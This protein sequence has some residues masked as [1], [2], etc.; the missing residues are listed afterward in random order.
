MKT[1]FLTGDINWKTYGGKFITK[2]L[3]NGDFDYYIVIEFINM[4]EATGDEK[5]DKYSVSIQ[6]VSTTEAG[7]KNIKSALD[8]CGIDIET[9]PQE[10]RET[11]IIE[12]LS[13]YGVYATLKTLSG[14]NYRKVLTQAH[15]ELQAITCL[16]GFYMDRPENRIGSTGWDMIKG[17]VLAGL[18]K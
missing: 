9:I 7:E 8:C 11:A 3:N 2:K 1:R 14:N 18:S 12:V 13:T 10:H 4:H 16:F 17:N 6:A 15:K 5:Q